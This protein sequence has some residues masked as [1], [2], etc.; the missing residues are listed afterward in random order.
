MVRLAALVGVLAALFA[1]P[2]STTP[3]NARPVEAPGVREQR[4]DTTGHVP[5][6]DAPVI[7]GFRPPDQPWLP[8]NRGLEY[9]TDPGQ[10]VRASASGTVTFAGQVGGDLF[11]TVLHPGGL[12]TTVGY[13]GS[14]LVSV[15]DH[16]TRGQVIALAGDSIHFTAR[17]GD[18]YIDP[19]SLFWAV[20]V[21]VRLVPGARGD[22]GGEI[23]RDGA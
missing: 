21:A 11:V 15:G 19:D 1:P 8:G 6:V 9:D 7:D 2:L 3:L 16:V 5:P 4:S 23:E 17:R 22:R 14:V 20:R 13:L 18:R 10:V 12:R